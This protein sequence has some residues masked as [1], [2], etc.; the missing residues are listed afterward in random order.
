MGP[1]EPRV[2]WVVVLMV[3]LGVVGACSGR[4][5]PPTAEGI[6]L[7]RCS[8]CHEEDGSSATASEMA[9]APIDLRDR[10]FQK[11]IT[12]REIRTI[13]QHGVGRMQGIPNL[14]SAQID[15]LVLHVRRLGS[16]PAS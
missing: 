3:V 4:S 15:S 11:N 10:F 7:A 1:A 5:Y 2:P 12:D 6:F 16:S 14:T 9:S 13:I 8:R